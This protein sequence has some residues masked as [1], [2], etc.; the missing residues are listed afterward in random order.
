MEML[1]IISTSII[2]A[3]TIVIVAIAL[4]KG[5]YFFYKALSNTNKEIA[6]NNYFTSFNLINAIWVPNGLTSKGREYRSKAIKK[7]GVFIILTVA[8]LILA[9]ITGM[10]Y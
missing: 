3:I 9:N 4:F 2:F 1:G 10:L 7:L 5:L 6:K 8:M